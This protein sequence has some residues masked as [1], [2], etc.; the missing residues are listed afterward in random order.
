MLVADAAHAIYAANTLILL[1]DAYL[2]AKG[3]AGGGGPTSDIKLPKLIQPAG[4][5]AAPASV[6]EQDATQQTN[7]QEATQRA[8]GQEA[9]QQ[10]NGQEATQPN[11]Q[12]ATQEVNGQEA[13]QEVNGQEATQQTNGQEATQEVNGGNTPVTTTKGNLPTPFAF[14]LRGAQT[15]MRSAD[16]LTYQRRRDAIYDDLAAR[17]ALV[18]ATMLDPEQIRAGW[19][20]LTFRGIIYLAVKSDKAALDRALGHP[21]SRDKILPRLLGPEAGEPIYY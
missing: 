20:D 1:V 9:T 21:G 11:G 18:Q 8:N 10:T 19:D 6:N 17:D 16:Y 12:E 3:L 2:V 14:L 4:E 13:T 15:N 7:G 5:G